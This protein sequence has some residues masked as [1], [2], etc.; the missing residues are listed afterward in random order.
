MSRVSAHNQA[1]AGAQRCVPDADAEGG[2]RRAVAVV[3]PEAARGCAGWLARVQRWCRRRRRH[4][5]T[6]RA[7][8][9]ASGSVRRASAAS[10][11]STAP[12]RRRSRAARETLAPARGRGTGAVS[13]RMSAAAAAAA[14]AAAAAGAPEHTA[15]ARPTAP[16]PLAR[17]RRSGPRG[18]RGPRRDSRHGRRWRARRRVAALPAGAV[19]GPCAS[20]FSVAAVVSATTPLCVLRR[21]AR[22][23]VAGG[24]QHGCCGGRDEV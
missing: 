14:V 7:S 3:R 18:R 24:L 4:A 23:G 13:L 15:T 2:R 11:P 20:D 6:S 17:A 1:A 5:C 19:A 21:E 22:A 9:L 12:P 16:A 8:C 10:A